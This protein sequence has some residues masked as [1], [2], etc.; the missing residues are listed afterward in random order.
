M[1]RLIALSLL[2][3][4][5]MVSTQIAESRLNCSDLSQGNLRCMAT[6]RD[7]L[8]RFQGYIKNKYTTDVNLDLLS[9]VDTCERVNQPPPR[10]SSTGRWGNSTT[11]N[12]EA[13]PLAMRSASALTRVVKRNVLIPY[14]DSIPLN[15]ERVRESGYCSATFVRNCRTASDERMNCTRLVSIQ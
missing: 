12:R 11:T 9:V 4:V 7:S 6:N 8:D 14:G 10:R 13:W 1:S 3:S 15:L 5:I 2:V